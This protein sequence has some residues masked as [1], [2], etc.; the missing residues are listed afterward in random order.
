MLF[1]IILHFASLKYKYRYFH[2][3]VSNRFG[4]GA[5]LVYHSPEIT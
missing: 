4:Q 5:L 2:F 1:D 3:I